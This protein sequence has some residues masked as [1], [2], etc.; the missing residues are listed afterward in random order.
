MLA[1]LRPL[2]AKGPVSMNLRRAPA[3]Q[4][5][6]FAQKAFTVDA[7]E[8][9]TFPN[10]KPE[11][12]NSYALNWSL[13]DSGVTPFEGAF[14][15]LKPSA[16]AA[17]GG[18]LSLAEPKEVKFT[19]KPLYKSVIAKLESRVLYVQD[20]ALGTLADNELHVRIIS[21]NAAT[22]AP[23]KALCAT[24]RS[25]DLTV[26]KEDVTV[27]SLTAEDTEW[28]QEFVAS[29]KA[30]K[31]IVMH[32]QLNANTLIKHMSVITTDA[33][34]AKGVLP[35]WGSGGPEVV[36]L[37]AGFESV[38]HIQHGFAWSEAGFCRLLM[39]Q[40]DASGSVTN[41]YDA[42]PNRIP[43]P[44]NVVMFADDASAT[45]PAASELDPA[46][47]PTVPPL[48]ALSGSTCCHPG[49]NPEANLETISPGYHPILV[50]IVWELTKEIINLPPGCVQG[51]CAHPAH[52][53]S[54]FGDPPC[55]QGCVVKKIVISYVS[56]ELIPPVIKR[57]TFRADNIS[58]RV[59]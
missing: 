56:W 22:V 15:N 23:F 44:K 40:S 29:S 4:R 3:Q 19:K 30:E 8:E 47:V 51:G 45:I 5:R 1:R 37:S 2:A 24:A 34:L 25:G 14:R 42:V 33:F 48:A 21:D 59:T 53:A 38:S 26:Y 39:G 55:M 12:G 58:A 27:L 36:Y 18:T 50:A 9:R 7:A 10:E 52:T 41:L 13:N 31:V 43:A 17:A 28:G 6:G 46:Q 54:R 49:G 35:L 20:S 11:E 32:G 57:I 16:L